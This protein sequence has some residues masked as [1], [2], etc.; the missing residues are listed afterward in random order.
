[1]TQGIIITID[2]PAGAG[3]S[4]LGQFLARALGYLYL[5]SGALYRAV[6]W[7]GRRLGL[8]LE[9]G[10]ALQAMLAEFQP[11]ATSDD[12]GFHL[13]VG[14]Q[15]ITGEL[16]TP[17]VSRD[18]SRVAVQPVVRQW[19]NDWLRGFADRRGVVAEGR[20][21][22][23]VVFPD[24][25]VKFYLEAALEVRAGRR[26]QEW[27][28]QGGAPAL[29]T[30]AQ[31]LAGRDRRDETRAEAPLQVPQGAFR[32]DTSRLGPEEVGRQ[33]LARIQKIIESGRWE[34]KPSK[35]V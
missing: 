26:R 28:A 11:R 20:D 23:S 29:E 24:A 15:E 5:D 21:L 30:V 33:C 2:G 12:R 22:G 4:T 7:Q 14:G 19:V 3:K 35:P 10:R 34:Y 27:E 18:A 8:D 32:I 9:D 13:W 6:A 31:E 1:M 17:Q 16:R 25:Q